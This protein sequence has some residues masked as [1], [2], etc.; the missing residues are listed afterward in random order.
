MSKFASFIIRDKYVESIADWLI[1]LYRRAGFLP[2]FPDGFFTVNDVRRRDGPDG[3]FSIN[4]WC[5]EK[6]MQPDGGW[7]TGDAE[8]EWLAFD[9]FPAPHGG[10]WFLSILQQAPAAEII[11]RDIIARLSIELDRQPD[12][13]I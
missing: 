9:F 7:A 5:V 2:A 8:G 10:T 3:K 12:W 1:R 4:L 11:W 13:P 6:T